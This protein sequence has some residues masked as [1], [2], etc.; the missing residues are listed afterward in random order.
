M[1][2]QMSA[3]EHGLEK[4]ESENGVSLC[5][6]ASARFR[7]VTFAIAFSLF[8][9]GCLGG[10]KVPPLDV[11]FARAKEQT[12]KRPVIIIPGVLGTELVNPRTQE[13]VW[14]Q[15]SPV[16]DDGLALPV[17][18]DLAANRDSLVAT[19]II[20]RTKI[21]R[22]L[23]EVEVYDALNRAMQ[24][25][26]G[27]K[28]GD[29]DDPPDGGDRDTYYIFAYDWRRDNVENARLLMQKIERLKAR[30]GRQDLRFNVIAHSM[31]GL[32]ARYAAMYGDADL[33][34]NSGNPAPNWSGARHFNKIFMFGT[35]NEG[36][37]SAFEGFTRGY[38][39]ETLTGKL[40]FSSLD[41]EALFTAPS[42]FQL[43]PHGNSARFYDENLNPL[44]IDLYDP[45]TW[46]R[47]DWG[48]ISNPAF[49]NKFKDQ[50]TANAKN[51]KKS[52]FAETSLEQLNA[53]FEVVLKRAK[54]FHEALNADTAVPAG[55]SFFVFGSDC[56]RTLDGAVIRKNA[57]TGKWQTLFSP[58]SYT[59]AD[60]KKISKD[61]L[62]KLL[63][64]PGDSRVT[65]RSL[66][67]ET[68][69]EQNVR[70]SIF[71]RTLPVT[72]TLFCEYHGDLTNNKIVQNNFLTA[73]ISEV[74]Q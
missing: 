39:V 47:Y 59:T 15:T 69:A 22:F 50:L 41:A 40:E 57:K 13:R 35:P 1:K 61:Q 46:R 2:P 29:W 64:A 19:Q 34:E 37:M 51:G 11:I 56:D 74:A 49:L 43:L 4:D 3:D 7:A 28:Q 58:R 70:N 62:R 67:A 33:H 60:G 27:Y 55:V 10:R 23:P 14:F 17:S 30:L 6:S 53:Y 36:S 25:Y 18:P 63:Y 24:N 9:T 42:S 45:E 68:I 21:F 5:V 48:A 72:A 20:E 71:R 52:E 65:R 38:Y 8:L 16:G 32:I 54:L 12:G 44:E 26:G 31:G 66:L 73:L